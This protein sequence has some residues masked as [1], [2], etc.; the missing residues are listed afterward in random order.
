M[1]KKIS[2]DDDGSHCNRFPYDMIAL[3]VRW[4]LR[5]H[6]PYADVAK[7]LVER[8]IHV[9]PSTI[10]DWVQHFTPLYQEAARPHRLRASVATILLDAGMA[11]DQLQKFLG[12]KR[13]ATTQIYAETS[14]RGMGESYVRAL[15]QR[16]A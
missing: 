11:F 15:E 1:A 2:A 14:L 10:F 5:Y 4:Y 8:G 3:A 12:H 7:L 9:D 13:I 6:V 16:Y